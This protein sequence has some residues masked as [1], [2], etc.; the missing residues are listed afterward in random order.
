MTVTPAPGSPAPPR[1]ASSR[2]TG[3]R[4]LPESRPAQMSWPRPAVP[5][6]VGQPQLDLG[7]DNDQDEL[8]PMRTAAVQLIR[9]RER[10]TATPRAGLPDAAAWAA[11]LAPAVLQ[12]MLAQRPISQLTRWLADDVLT[13]VSLHQRQRRA[14]RGRRAVP[15]TLRSVRVQ[16]PQ[17]EAA[18][19]CAQLVVG[20]RR[21]PMAMRLEALGERWLCTA[22]ELGPHHPD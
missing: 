22:L 12:A 16:H 10:W 5:D 4:V 17:P 11:T 9:V 19:V 6:S 20:Q 1:T 14:E 7:S 21:V 3:V 18:E 2:T 8:P 13:A 15:V